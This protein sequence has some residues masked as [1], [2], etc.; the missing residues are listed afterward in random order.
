MMNIEKNEL[1]VIFIMASLFLVV[2]FIQS[3]S[4]RQWV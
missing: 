2:G 4:L 3:W 1:V